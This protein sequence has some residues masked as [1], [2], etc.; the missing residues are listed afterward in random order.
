VEELSKVSTVAYFTMQP[1]WL[2]GESAASV[3]ESFAE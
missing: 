1:M 3:N 2:T